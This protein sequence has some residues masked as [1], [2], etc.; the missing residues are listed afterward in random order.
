MRNTFTALRLCLALPFL[1][2]M[3]GPAGAAAEARPVTAARAAD[4]LD[5]LG[6]CTHMAQGI[7]DPTKSA[8]C[9]TY[10]G[11]RS[12]RDDGSLAHVPD[13]IAVHKQSGAR[14]CLLTNRDIPETLTMAERLNAAGALLAVEGPNEPNNWPVTYEGQKSGYDTTALPIARFQAALYQAVKADPALKGIPVFH[15][16]EAGGS[17]K[18]NAGL[19]FLTIPPGAGTLM[20]DGTKFADYANTHNYVC[21]HSSV[22]VDNAGWNATSPTLNADWDGL[23]VEYGRTWHG[24]FPGYTD[25]QLETLPRVCTETGWTTQGKGSLTPEQQGRVLLNLYLD[26]FKRG[27]KYTFVYMLRDDPGQGSWGLFDTNYQPKASAT[28]LHNLTTLLAESAKPAKAAKLRTLA[29]AI[30]NR[31]ATVH[32]LLLQKRDGTL[33]LAVWDERAS[34]SDTITVD[35]GRA[36]A[37][38]T[39]SDPTLGT[40]P[41]KTLGRVRSVPLTLSDHPVLLT[42]APAR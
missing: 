26:G 36:Q 1:T 10:A 32:D 34:G 6:V 25:A 24:H 20:P 8:A 17:E 19:Q 7:D 30:P 27:W 39:L 42:L 13:W 23:Y 31:P 2:A 29:Y 16:S 21:G 15:S 28:Y 37:G 11:I 33:I 41:V 38:V 5:S 22:L 12:L 4:F 3:T 35:L 14:V 40:A 9:L 18:D